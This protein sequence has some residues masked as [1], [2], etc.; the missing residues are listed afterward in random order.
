MELR[1]TNNREIT[2]CK[3][4]VKQFD[5][6]TTTLTFIR[7]SYK[8]DQIDLRNYKA[9]AVTSLN[10]E[11]DMTELTTAVVGSELH[12]T[13]SLGKTLSERPLLQQH[14]AMAYQ[15][16]FKQNEGGAAV[17]STY[18]GII[19]NS[20]S[21]DADSKLTADYP[22][23]MKQWLDLINS[24]SAAMHTEIVYMPVGGSIPIQERNIN[25]LYYQWE[26]VPTTSAVAANGI[27]NLGKNPYA[28]SGL[29][30]NG[31]HVYVD[32][33]SET[34]FVTDP[35]VWVEAINAANVG[36]IASDESLGDEIRI[37]L[38]ASTAGEAGNSITYELGLAQYGAGKGTNN[39]SG[40]KTQGSTLYGGSDA[41][42]G[43]DTPIG[44]FEDH[45]GNVLGAT[46]AKDVGDIDLNQ[47]TSTGLYVCR[48]EVL[49]A[50]IDSII[51]FV[52][53]TDS[54]ASWGFIL[55]ECYID[56]GT[57]LR[58]FVRYIRA[59]GNRSQWRELTPQVAVPDYRADAMKVLTNNVTDASSGWSYTAENHGT[60]FLSLTGLAGSTTE[61]H[62]LVN[63]CDITVGSVTDT[64]ETF[65]DNVNVTVPLAKGDVLTLILRNGSVSRLVFVPNKLV[66]A[67]E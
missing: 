9:Y 25:T 18:Q 34:V 45:F 20:A 44:H 38:T 24:R 57:G 16:V 64:N 31:T 33:S 5:Y 58:I 41:I 3:I 8:Y 4:A 37:L 11:I 32:N 51:S 50:P 39:P 36:V 28:D 13:W 40:G 67:Y 29:Y 27:V 42:T 55:Q 1:I 62:V 21:I 2:P 43:V 22:T 35:A 59:D 66:P 52:R 15:I 17:F 54:L 46:G 23:I 53:V 63:N 65:P 19:Q 30:I 61:Y 14:G 49:N 60:M 7:D 56:N 12:I 6:N 48:G 26:E 10:G 47:L